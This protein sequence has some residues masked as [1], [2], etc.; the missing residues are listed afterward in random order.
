MTTVHKTKLT[1]RAKTGNAYRLA[2][3]IGQ[4]RPGSVRSTTRR[5]ARFWNCSPSTVIVSDQD[6]KGTLF[7]WDG[8]GWLAVDLGNNYVLGRCGRYARLAVVTLDSPIAPGPINLRTAGGCLGCDL[9]VPWGEW[10]V[11]VDDLAD[12]QDYYGDELEVIW[13]QG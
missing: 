8:R 10:I 4:E 7:A 6:H 13:Q 5:P 9:D 11:D 12:L 1:G 3:A 2:R